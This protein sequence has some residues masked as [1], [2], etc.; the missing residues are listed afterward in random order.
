MDSIAKG[1]ATVEIMEK[2][3]K[4]N[5]IVSIV[6]LVILH[7]VNAIAHQAGLVKNAKINAMNGILVKIAHLSAYVRKTILWHAII[8]QENAS[9]KLKVEE[10]KQ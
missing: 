9:V 10:V 7:Q 5:V 1:H 6:V 3:V 8:K 4:R 2:T